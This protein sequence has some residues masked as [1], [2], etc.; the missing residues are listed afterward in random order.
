MAQ[1]PDTL[2]AA[3]CRLDADGI[4]Y[5][6]FHGETSEVEREVTLRRFHK[7]PG[8]STLPENMPSI[9]RSQPQSRSV[10]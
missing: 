2:R 4:G 10:D 9:S 1:S 3:S 7:K 6:L 5:A 8:F